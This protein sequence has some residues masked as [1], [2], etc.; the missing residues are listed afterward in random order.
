MSDDM[1]VKNGKLLVKRDSF[2]RDERGL[3]SMPHL[4]AAVA[5]VFGV[6]CGVVALVS[7]ILAMVQVV[8]PAFVSQ[9][10][11][12][13]LNIGAGALL[14]AGGLEGGVLVSEHKRNRKEA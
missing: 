5:A 3:K 11:T 6:I 1:Q 9:G 12:I 10:W 8:D 7:W 13:A 2:L 14:A 4:V